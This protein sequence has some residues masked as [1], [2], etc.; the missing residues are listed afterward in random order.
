VP[1]SG[2]PSGQGPEK[3]DQANPVVQQENVEG[4]L[5]TD[6]GQAI[7]VPAKKREDA[8]ISGRAGTEQD[9]NVGL[10]GG[11]AAVRCV[12]RQGFRWKMKADF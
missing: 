2:P 7:C 10:L 9:V 3:L 8:R 5:K 1:Q 12:F 11:K 6:G 4:R